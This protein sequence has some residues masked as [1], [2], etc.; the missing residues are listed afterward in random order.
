MQMHSKFR[1]RI[2]CESFSLSASFNKFKQE[3]FF[4]A[5][6]TLTFFTMMIDKQISWYFVLQEIVGIQT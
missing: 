5:S 6:L 1:N 4:L 3:L 2:I